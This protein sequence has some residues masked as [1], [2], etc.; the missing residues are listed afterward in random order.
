VAT[1]FPSKLR[2]NAPAAAT[3]DPAKLCQENGSEGKK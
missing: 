3:E 1:L 2:S